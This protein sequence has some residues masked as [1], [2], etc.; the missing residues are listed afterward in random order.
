[1]TKMAKLS[2]KFISANNCKKNIRVKPATIVRMDKMAKVA[3]M[4]KLSK[5]A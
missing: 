5:M 4:A 2:K 1:M 3:R